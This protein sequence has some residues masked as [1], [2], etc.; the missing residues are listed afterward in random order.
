MQPLCPLRFL[1]RVAFTIGI[2]ALLA[3]SPMTARDL[4]ADDDPPEATEPA[5]AGTAALQKARA[6][7]DSK[8]WSGA[9]SE[10]ETA[11]DAFPRNADVYNL[12]GYANRK[13]RRF[14]RAIRNY[15]LALKLDPN[16][17]GALEYLGEFYIETG[18]IEKARETERYLAKLCPDGCEEFTDL[19]A[20]IA[21]KPHN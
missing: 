13:L 14:E 21:G 12:L 5:D 19:R 1:S 15:R 8:D 7:I 6:L 9:V 20:A 2:A 4:A 18:R 10:L 3:V 16:H 17:K 11:R